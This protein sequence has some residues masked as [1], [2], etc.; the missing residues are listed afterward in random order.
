MEA[1]QGHGNEQTLKTIP[2]KKLPGDELSKKDF[3]VVKAD[4]FKP[5]TRSFQTVF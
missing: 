5:I 3:R 4:E 2:Q 1:I